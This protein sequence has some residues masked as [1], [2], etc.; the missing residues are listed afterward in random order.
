MR[1]DQACR[2][3]VVEADH[4][5]I[6]VLL[7]HGG[8]GANG[9]AVPEARQNGEGVAGT[10]PQELADGRPAVGN[11]LGPPRTER[12]NQ[13]ERRD[14]LLESYTGLLPEAIDVLGSEE[15][16]QLYRMIGMKAH[17]SLDGSFDLSKDVI[18]FSKVV[19]SP[20]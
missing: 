14:T 11:A 15:R 6:E 17:L 19:I 10:L 8:D 16:H 1:I 2:E 18:N 9:P 20:S 13:L 5:F 4:A 7:D 12:L 3:F